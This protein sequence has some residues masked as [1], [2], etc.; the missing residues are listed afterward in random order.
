MLANNEIYFGEDNR[1]RPKLKR[2]RCDVKEGITYPTIWDFVPLNTDGSQEMAELFNDMKAFENPKPT[3]L[4]VELAKL[5]SGPGHI[6]LDFFAGLGTTAHA[7]I[8]LNREDGGNRKYILVEMANYFDNVLLPRIKKVVFSDDWKDGKPQN[9]NGIRH[10]LKYHCLE[11]YEDSLD[12]LELAPDKTAQNLFGND[13]LLKYF[14]DFETQDNPSLI[15]IEHLKK[16]FSYNF[17]VNLEEV[18]EPQEVI[19]DIPETFHYL[20]GLTVI[21]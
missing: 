14:L 15:N 7:V 2:F 20:L 4:I 13:Y 21:K 12:N 16:P 11:Q 5:G 8:N 18:G 6:I 1:G 17:K 10:F 9:S 3:G 19:V